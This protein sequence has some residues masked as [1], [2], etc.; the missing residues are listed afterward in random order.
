MEAG[1][2]FRLIA[3]RAGVVE[4]GLVE[5]QRS[6]ED[7]QA[8]LDLAAGG[9]QAKAAVGHYIDAGQV[10]IAGQGARGGLE[11]AAMKALAEFRR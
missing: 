5:R 10:V 8:A 11:A 9:A 7:R 1:A 6:A 3:E 2:A 4:L